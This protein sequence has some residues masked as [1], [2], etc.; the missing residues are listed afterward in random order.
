MNTLLLQDE[1]GRPQVNGGGLFDS[2]AF[3]RS[4]INA[5]FP[6][7]L[8]Q[9]GVLHNLPFV[10]LGFTAARIIPSIPADAQT[11]VFA[12]C[13]PDTFTIFIQDEF[14][15]GFRIPLPLF[16]QGAHGQK[17]MSMG[18]PIAV[19]M[20]SKIRNHAAI[21]EGRLAVIADQFNVLFPGQFLGQ[22]DDN[23]PSGLG[24]GFLL[25]GIH[26]VPERCPIPVCFRGVGRQQDLC[27]DDSFQMISCF[28]FV[29]IS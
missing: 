14:S 7:G 26:R 3:E 18:I 10:P 23:A 11:F 20:D 29:L 13:R 15:P 22:S 25:C 27:V 16:V 24:C 28:P 1:G 6:S 2:L 19:I 4:H 8:L 5:F 12:V 21:H 9:G 17:Y